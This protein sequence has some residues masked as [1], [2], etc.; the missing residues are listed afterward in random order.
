MSTCN[1][2]LVGMLMVAFTAVIGSLLQRFAQKTKPRTKS[3]LAIAAGGLFGIRVVRLKVSS[4][5]H[6]DLMGLPK[7]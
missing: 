7:V 3:Q 5:T 1:G 6:D 4:L 2:A